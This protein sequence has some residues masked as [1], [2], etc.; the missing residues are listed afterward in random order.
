MLGRDVDIHS[1]DDFRNGQWICLGPFEVFNFGGSV[2]Q[3]QARNIS[4]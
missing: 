3:T 1:L 2:G 4:A